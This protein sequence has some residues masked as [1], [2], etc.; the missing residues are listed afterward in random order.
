M[1]SGGHSMA[2]TSLRFF[3]GQTYHT[4]DTIPGDFQGGAQTVYDLT[5]GQAIDSHVAR[6]GTG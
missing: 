1:N 5:H 6:V 3:K 2:V 4:G